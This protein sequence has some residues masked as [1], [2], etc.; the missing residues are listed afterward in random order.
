MRTILVTG[1]TGYIGSQMVAKL[2]ELNLKPVIIDNF[3]NSKSTVLE[4]IKK[5][6]SDKFD[7]FK[8]DICDSAL[9]ASIFS[10]YKIDAVIHFAGLKAVSESQSKPLDYYVN[11][12][13]GS[14]VLFREMLKAN[15]NKLIFSSSAT[16]YGTPDIV[17]YTEDLPTN[18]VNVYGKTKLAVENIIKD[19]SNANIKF[20]GI[21]LRYFNPVGAHNSGL[22]GDDP[23]GIPNNLLPYIGQVALG[24]LPLLKIFGNDYAT[25][26]GTGMRDYIHVEDLVSGHLMALDYLNDHRGTLVVNL[27]N[28]TPRS[29]LEVVHTFERISCTKIP[30]QFVERR[31]GDLPIY[32]ANAQL[33]KNILGWSA[34]LDLEQMCED[35]WRFYKNTVKNSLYS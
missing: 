30:Y 3:I 22:I 15:V 23:L 21:C 8:G 32:F 16:V 29:V 34:K 13:Y 11:N 2:L 28:E 18:P 33:A 20:S 7:F 4:N 26:D 24:K 5:I 14:M 1:G 25:P 27:G 35:T 6:G 12:V 9:L 31:T 10:N 17:Q 19:I